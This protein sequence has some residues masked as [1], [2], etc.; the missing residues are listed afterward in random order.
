MKSFLITLVVLMIQFVSF[1]QE[2][3]FTTSKCKTS[4]NERVRKNCI[5]KEIQQFVDKNYDVASVM[6]HAQSG[7]NRIY[8][9][10]TVDATGQVSDVQ[11]K[12]SAFQLEIE[13]IR[14]LQTLPRLIP[15]SKNGKS[16]QEQV[17]TLPIIFEVNTTE[18]N[19]NE[20]LTGN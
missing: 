12:S 19:A 15:V 7:T 10:F 2:N 1:S 8:T 11:A 4:T 13:A 20:R 18:I 3:Y 9:R 6:A 14:V 16:V 5:I 17:F